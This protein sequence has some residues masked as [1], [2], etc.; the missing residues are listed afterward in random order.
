MLGRA[1]FFPRFDP[2]PPPAREPSRAA[3]RRGRA[4]LCFR[5]HAPDVFSLP[6]TPSYPPCTARRHAG[7]ARTFPCHPHRPQSWSGRATR[8]ARWGSAAAAWGISVF[9][10]LSARGGQPGEDG[11]THALAPRR[12][13]LRAVA[14][15]PTAPSI[16]GALAALTPRV[17]AAAS[18]TASRATHHRALLISPWRRPPACQRIR[19]PTLRAPARLAHAP[20]SPRLAA[21]RLSCLC[22]FVR[23]NAAPLASPTT[24]GLSGGV[25]EPQWRVF[26]S[27][28]VRATGV[29]CTVRCAP[30]AARRCPLSSRAAISNCT[31]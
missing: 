3:G 24:P 25:S 13:A 14:T 2:H 21:A 1:D 18:R 7:P 23:G 12:V 27:R 19:V 8:C 31:M 6:P 5:G 15:A 20:A 29:V 10:L 30:V 17:G 16:Q 22:I 9:C 4:P 26:T 28:R 11:G